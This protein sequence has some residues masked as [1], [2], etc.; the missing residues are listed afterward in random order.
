MKKKRRMPALLLAAVMVFLSACGSSGG[1][2]K[3]ESSTGKPQDNS[4]GQPEEAGSATVENDSPVTIDW[5]AYNTFGQPD[6]DAEVIRMIEEKFNVKFNFWFV[7]DQEWDQVLGIKFAGG[8][9]P[10]VLK[11][12]STTVVEKYVKQEILAPI[13]DEMLAKIPTLRDN[14][15]AYGGIDVTMDGMYNGDLYV[16]KTINLN[17]AYPTTLVWRTDWLENVGIGKIPGTIEEWEEAMYKFRNDDPDGNGEK[18]TYG[19]SETTIPAVFGAFG[20]IP[21]FGFT[22][23]DVP[24]LLWT[25]KDDQFVLAPTQPEMKEALAYL[26]KWYQDGLI[27]PEFITGENTAGYWAT[28]QA[29]TNGRVG[30]TGKSMSYHWN[31]PLMEEAAGGV[32]YTD[33]LSVNPDAVFGETVDLGTAPVGPSGAAGTT[34]WGAISGNGIA[35]TTKCVEDPVKLDAVLNLIESMSGDYENYILGMYGIEGEHYTVDAASGQI[36]VTEAYADQAAAVKA[37]LSVTNV[38]TKNPEFDK[39]VNPLLYAFMD[40]YDGP[41]YHGALVPVTESN[42][43]YMEDLKKYAQESYIKFITGELPLEE[44]ETFVETF[45]ANG[46]T[47]IEEETNAAIRQLIGG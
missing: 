14:I 4:A 36:T 35:F 24:D 39:K 9:M 41:G 6:A 12:K 29:F 5:L 38:M 43:M 2:G 16:L 13:T 44:F 1:P 8:E 45:N 28:S 31:P 17:G 19:M 20:T 26:S 27:D 32:C 7:D 34:E 23:K 25:K 30:V 18:D 46:G 37:G 47:V 33:F 3:P 15:E 21:M 42:T 22:G 10:D 40:Q 11:I